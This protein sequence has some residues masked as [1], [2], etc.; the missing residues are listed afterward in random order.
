M[1]RIRLPLF[2]FGTVAALLAPAVARSQTP[3][4]TPKSFQRIYIDAGE[5]RGDQTLLYDWPALTRL[6]VWSRGL[7]SAVSGADETLSAELLAGFRVRVDS[8]REGPLPEFLGE[9]A[10]S[11]GASLGR[12]DAILEAAEGSLS[13][14]PEARV[15]PREGEASADARNQRTLVTGSTAV[16]VPAGV[17]VGSA[18]DSLPSVTFEG[19]E[20]VTFVDRIG[21][22]LLEL[23]RVVHLTRTA[24]RSP[25]GPAPTPAGD[26]PPRPPGP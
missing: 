25:D 12:I 3:S 23:D 11:V 4:E 13:A 8:L 9:R 19:G 2:T 10:D 26:T 5:Y 17:A 20:A 21:L 1:T 16:T 22:A 24:S 7:E 6:V 14:I 15:T 18:R